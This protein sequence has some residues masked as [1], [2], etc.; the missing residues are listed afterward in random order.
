[1]ITKLLSGVA[2]FGVKV[3]IG[4]SGLLPSKL[5]EG[6]SAFG[7][8]ATIGVSGVAAKGGNA[9]DRVKV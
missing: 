3:T 4:G 5:L 6:V 1:M 8:K 7:G 9:T 2:D